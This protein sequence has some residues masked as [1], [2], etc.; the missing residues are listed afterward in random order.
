[1]AVIEVYID[2]ERRTRPVGPAR[3]NKVR[4]GDTVIFEYAL[5]WLTD[6]DRFA[7]RA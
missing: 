6:P 7:P 1:M 3:S 4:S 5:A 2:I